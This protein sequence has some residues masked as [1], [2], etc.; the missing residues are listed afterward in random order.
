MHVYVSMC[1]Y[2]SAGGIKMSKYEM[3]VCAY[4]ACMC[5]YMQ[6]YVC[7]CVCVC[8]LVYATEISNLQCLFASYSSCGYQHHSQKHAL[9]QGRV[10]SIGNVQTVMVILALALAASCSTSTSGP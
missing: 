1:M 7:V 2:T 8:V 4:I 9:T 10:L 5:K 6:V 3:H